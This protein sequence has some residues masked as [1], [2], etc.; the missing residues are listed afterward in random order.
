MNKNVNYLLIK[1]V[2]KFK[3]KVE[4]GVISHQQHSA[5][6]EL[7]EEAVKTKNIEK[8]TVPIYNG[9]AYYYQNKKTFILL[10]TEFPI[11]ELKAF[12]VIDKVIENALDTKLLRNPED[13]FL[14]HYIYNIVDCTFE[15]DEY[16]DLR[17]GGD[18]E[19]FHVNKYREALLTIASDIRSRK[20][21]SQSKNLKLIIAITIIV[22]GIVL[23]IVIPSVI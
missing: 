11:S 23:A 10:F 17:V 12:A 19:P 9:Y 20:S 3:H 8:T 14:L 1:D 4:I 18:C 13:E 22:I 5:I 2:K 16:V 21:E 6:N 7:F 15:E